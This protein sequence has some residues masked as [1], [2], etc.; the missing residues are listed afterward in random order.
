MRLTRECATAR[1]RLRLASTL[2]A[3]VRDSAI[4]RG[5]FMSDSHETTVRELYRSILN[6]DPDPGGLAH[7]IQ[8]L[9]REPVLASSRA[10]SWNR[11][12]TAAG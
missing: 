11:R 2:I 12:S 6:R 4:A 7:F 8:H 3:G 9:S 1:Y 5:F 10:L